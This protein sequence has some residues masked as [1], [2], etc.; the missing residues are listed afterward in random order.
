MIQSK[1]LSSVRDDKNV[2]RKEKER[3]KKEHDSA[4]KILEKTNPKIDGNV[5][6][7]YN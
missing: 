2:T 7:G 5:I 3:A 6:K 1:T 4:K